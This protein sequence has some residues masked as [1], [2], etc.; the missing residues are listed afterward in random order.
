MKQITLCADDFGQNQEISRGIL[1]LAMQHRLNAISCM[2]RCPEFQ[3]HSDAL[4]SLP[5]GIELGLHFTLTPGWPGL[6][7]LFL[8]LITHRLTKQ[9]IKDELSAQ[10][11]RFH[12]TIGRLPDFIDGHQHIHHFPIVRETL[13][14]TYLENYPQKSSWIRVSAPK[15]TSLKS[16]IINLTGAQTLQNLLDQEKIPHNTTF[17]GVYPFK[18]ASNYQHW[19]QKF[20]AES[21]EG[22]MIMCHPGRA[23][24]DTTDPL[25]SSRELELEYFNS[26]A[27]LND[28]QNARCS[29]PKAHKE[30]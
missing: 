2:T 30:I 24:R 4:H 9:S 16:I 8:D 27:F 7:R 21:E 13:L 20:L 11:E 22:G 18:Q 12:T 5:P 25:R 28:C 15:M 6:P 19:F 26:T 17:S 3:T 29:L 14:E 10:L 1:D 23:S